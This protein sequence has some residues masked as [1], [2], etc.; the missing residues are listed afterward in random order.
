MKYIKIII[1]ILSLFI[2]IVS[3]GQIGGL[4]ASKLASFSVG[5]VPSHKIEFEPS[6]SHLRSKTYWDNNGNKTNIFSTN[7]SV[8]NISAMSFRFTYGITDNLEFGVNVSPDVSMSNWGLRYV[9]HNGEDFG[10]AAITGMN[11]PLGNQTIDKRTRLAE[12]I[13]SI[14]LGGVM[15]YNFN[16]NFSAD[17][18]AQYQLHLEEAQHHDKNS[19]FL[20][21]DI[22]YYILKHQLQFAT[23]FAYRTVQDDF[24]GHNVFSITPGVTIETGETFIIVLY[25]PFDIIGKNEV[26]NHGF[27]FAIENCI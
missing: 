11:I 19:I 5:T 27:G 16:E 8:R 20:N 4:S 26:E 23:A 6:F 12:N 21:F 22:G 14:G 17:F 10:I 18:T 15:T 13:L 3:Y 25:A 24:G 7:D 9:I 1:F 2:S